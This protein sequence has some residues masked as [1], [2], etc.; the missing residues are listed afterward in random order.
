MA[1]GGGIALAAGDNCS[2]S[3]ITAVM[4]SSYFLS[5]SFHRWAG[6][7]EDGAALLDMIELN[8]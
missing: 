4:I 1:C 5:G 2:Y 8:V 7:L 3:T 6:C